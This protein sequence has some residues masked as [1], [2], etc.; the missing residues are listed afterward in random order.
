MDV[1]EHSVFVKTLF[2]N[3]ICMGFNWA[4]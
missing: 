2:F 4:C 3:K 1:E